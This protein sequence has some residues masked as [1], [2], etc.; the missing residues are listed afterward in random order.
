ME[1]RAGDRGSSERGEGRGRSSGAWCHSFVR[2]LRWGLF[3]HLCVD[4]TACDPGK[5]GK[6]VMCD[7]EGVRPWSEGNWHMERKAF[8]RMKRRTRRRRTVLLSWTRQKRSCMQT[9]DDVPRGP[10]KTGALPRGAL[11]FNQENIEMSW[12]NLR[13]EQK[14]WDQADRERAWESPAAQCTQLVSYSALHLK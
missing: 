8:H 13:S 7:V 5:K 2:S 3:H 10:G 6:F 11:G 12:G 14:G 4:R 1:R 9:Q